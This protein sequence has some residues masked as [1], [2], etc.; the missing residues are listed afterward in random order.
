MKDDRKGD[1]EIETETEA[2]VDNDRVRRGRDREIRHE[3]TTKGEG[4]LH[5]EAHSERQR[6]ARLSW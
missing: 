6:V 5:L 1:S 2:T 3:S 4:A